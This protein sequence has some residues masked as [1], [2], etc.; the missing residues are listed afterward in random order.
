MSYPDVANPILIF[1][2][3]ERHEVRAPIHEIVHLHQIYAL[4]AQALQRLFHLLNP[5]FAPARPDFSGEKELV[6]YT[7]LVCEVADD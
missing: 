2:A 1:P 6:S 3:P 4:H 5:R 7:Q